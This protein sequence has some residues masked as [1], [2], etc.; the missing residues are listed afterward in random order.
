MWTILGCIVFSYWVTFP[1]IFLAIVYYQQWQ[2]P[3]WFLFSFTTGN[4]GMFFLSEWEEHRTRDRE[5]ANG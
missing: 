3:A 1:F 4:V 5:D 2:A